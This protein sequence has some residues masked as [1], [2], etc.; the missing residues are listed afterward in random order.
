MNG[1]AERVMLSASRALERG[2]VRTPGAHFLAR[3][4]EASA[5]SVRR[6]RLPTSAVVIGIG[7]PTLGGS[8]KTPLT[9]ALA[10][11]LAARGHRVSVVASGYRGRACTARRVRVDDAVDDVGDEA[12]W[13]ARDLEAS[14]VPV[15]VGPDRETALRFAATLA[16]RILVDALLQ[17]APRRLALSILVADGERPL[18]GGRCPPEGDLRARASVMLAAADV[19]VAVADSGRSTMLP[20]LLGHDVTIVHGAV[21]AAHPV[22][23]GEPVRLGALTARSV[24]VVL[25]IAHPERVLRALAAHGIRPTELRLFVDHGVPRP[26]PPAAVS[27]FTASPPRVAVPELWLATAKCA[28]KLGTSFEGAPVYVL[29]HRLQLPAS[30]VD[31]VAAATAHPA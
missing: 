22:A 31:A 16:P 17:T 10:T 23:G 14:G 3:L 21:E 11:E 28:T 9:L 4:W 15:V 20:S 7:G 24:G 13:L 29:A 19:V 12:L 1:L 8:F 6:V 26:R 5:R 25:A 30:L 27:R 2:S 18:G